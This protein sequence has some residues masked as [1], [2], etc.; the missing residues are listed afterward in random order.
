MFKST[1]AYMN[2]LITTAN[3][4]LL[5]LVLDI[6]RKKINRTS[7]IKWVNTIC[8]PLRLFMHFKTNYK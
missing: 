2:V 4:T 6:S 1:L 5:T 7:I 3:S 8:K